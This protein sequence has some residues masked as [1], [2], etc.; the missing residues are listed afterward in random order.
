M[1]AIC[2]EAS[3]QRGMGHLFRAITL[4]HY[5][6]A[7]GQHA[8]ILLNDDKY[9]LEILKE[10]NIYHMVVPLENCEENW[11]GFLIQNLGIDFWINDRM[12]TCA[13]EGQNVKA[14]QIPL[15]AFDDKGE[16]AYYTDANFM[17]MTFPVP[18][19]RKWGLRIY[20]GFS[21]LLLNPELQKYRR[22]RRQNKKL[23]V[24]LGGSDSYGVSCIIAQQLQDAGLQATLFLGPS[25]EHWNKL[26]RIVGKGIEIKKN[27][28]SLIAELSHY[29]LAIT[30]G[31]ITCLEAAAAGLPPLIVANEKH[32]V[33]IA[34]HLAERAAAC[35]IGYR[36]RA[37]L[38]LPLP[39]GEEIESM[40]R[41]AMKNVPCNGIDN[42][43]KALKRTEAK[44]KTIII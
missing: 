35:Y 34:L 43:Y 6:L 2:I 20:S 15:A 21:Y 25:Y 32:E 41:A 7:K 44:W 29:D 3:H 24:T 38:P 17:A 16:G 5:L 28:P 18:V 22:L 10:R 9:A 26:S 1:Y 33:Q 36:H 11:Q 8:I 31:G 27:V 14:E 40:S 12:D 39:S 30:G 37:S 23:A 4:Y 13:E 19:G 42:I